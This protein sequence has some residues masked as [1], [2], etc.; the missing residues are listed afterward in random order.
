[1]RRILAAVHGDNS[2]HPTQMQ[3]PRMTFKLPVGTVDLD[4]ARVIVDAPTFVARQGHR[5]IQP[6]RTAGYLDAAP[7]AGTAV[8][9]RPF[10]RFLH[11]DL[12]AAARCSR[13]APDHAEGRARQTPEP[14]QERDVSGPACR[15]GLPKA[16]P[17]C[18]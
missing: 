12:A 2:T 17:H 5:S 9:G 16:A 18:P 6:G 1:M 15:T 13:A 14:R 11:M 3:W 4:S 10:S 7:T 8:D